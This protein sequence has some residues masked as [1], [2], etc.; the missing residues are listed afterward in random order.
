MTLRTPQFITRSRSHRESEG[1]DVA[2]RDAVRLMYPCERGGSA[3]LV[4]SQG[5][6]VQTR[7]RFRP[8]FWVH[9]AEQ[10]LKLFALQGKLTSRGQS[11]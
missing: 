10:R 11:P 7:D 1:A 5:A 4:Q 6:V 2:K 9:I 8:L 3:V